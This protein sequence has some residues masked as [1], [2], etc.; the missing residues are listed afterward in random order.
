MFLGNFENRRYDNTIS[1]K[2][3]HYVRISYN[4]NSSYTWQNMQHV[5]WTLY[6]SNIVSQLLV[7]EDCPYFKDG[8][9]TANFTTA[10]VLGPFNELYQRKG[11]KKFIFCFS[12]YC[13][14]G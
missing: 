7:G 2:G 1:K 5:T 11:N 10:G 9:R 4:R 3:D 12:I 13:D 8:Y 6:R 14:C